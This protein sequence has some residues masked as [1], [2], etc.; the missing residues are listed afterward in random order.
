MLN[1]DFEGVSV[2]EL[3]DPSLHNWVHH[4]QYILPQ[5]GTAA[6]C[7]TNYRQNCYFIVIQ[8]AYIVF[9]G[10]CVWHNPVEKPEDDFEE[11]EEEE[12]RED[13]EEPKPESGPQLLTS[14]AEDEGD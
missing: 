7:S 4:V 10:R 5:V 2:R 11:E 1:V 13:V 8:T 14:I 6:D 3:A 9:Q 12:E